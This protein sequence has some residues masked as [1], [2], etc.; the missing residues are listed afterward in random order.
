MCPKKNKK[1]KYMESVFD[2]TRINGFGAHRSK[3][4][5]SS[6]SLKLKRPKELGSIK[7]E[8]IHRNIKRE[9]VSNDY[10]LKSD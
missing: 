4:A 7:L 5:N 2:D 8:I 9:I 6:I 10:H 1:A 3:K